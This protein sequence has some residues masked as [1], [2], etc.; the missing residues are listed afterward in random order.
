[1]QG[2]KKWGAISFKQKNVIKIWKRI[3]RNCRKDIFYSFKVSIGKRTK[4]INTT[5]NVYSIANKK[6]K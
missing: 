3:K 1:M 6:H 5:T 2:K 4:N